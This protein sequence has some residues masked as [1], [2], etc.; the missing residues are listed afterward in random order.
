M[1]AHIV[2]DSAY[3]NTQS[4][5]EAIAGKLHPLHASAV[6]VPEFDLRALAPGDLLVVGSPVN[7]WR[8]TARVTALLA[9][10]GNGRLQGIN[11]AAF[12]TRIRFFIHGDAA[13]KMT[14]MLE[15]GGARIISDPAVFYVQ[16]T[17]GPLRN[18]ELDKAGAWAE[19]LLSKVSRG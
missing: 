3:G 4:V 6:P 16:G 15:E 5:A 10:L 17:E 13:R 8:P 2:Y 1:K 11:A 12:D 18:G 14:R 7:G 19:A 9:Q